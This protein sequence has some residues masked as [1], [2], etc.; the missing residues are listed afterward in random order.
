MAQV[1]STQ[2][3]TI[4]KR[5]EYKIVIKLSDEVEQKATF[6]TDAEN[7]LDKVNLA[8][9]ISNEVDKAV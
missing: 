3:K 1:S 5:K 6:K 8:I 9:N 7:I 4:K 2:L